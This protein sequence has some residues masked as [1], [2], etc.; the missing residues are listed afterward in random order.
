MLVV[1]YAAF[2]CPECEKQQPKILRGV[3][4][5][6]VPESNWDYLIVSTV[7][8]ITI[9]T[10]FFAIKWIVKPGET[11][12]NHIKYSPLIFE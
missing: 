12:K 8:A 11:E 5:G 4:H 10:L 6:N 3:V 2:A 9:F 1:S 7:A